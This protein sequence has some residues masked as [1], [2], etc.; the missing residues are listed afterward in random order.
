MTT[1][2][3]R[4]AVLYGA[5]ATMSG[6]LGYLIVLA[7]AGPAAGIPDALFGQ[8]GLGW[9]SGTLLLA[10]ILLWTAGNVSLLSGLAVPPEQS[11]C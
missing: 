9:L 7:R 11:D 6:I 5:V 2:P 10:G 8:G 1:D 3:G 4:Q